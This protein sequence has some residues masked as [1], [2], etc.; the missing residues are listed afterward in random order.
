SGGDE[1][2]GRRDPRTRLLALG[3][4][5][6]AIATRRGRGRPHARLLGVAPLDEARRG[7]SARRPGLPADRR[8]RLAR[9]EMVAA[10]GGGGGCFVRAR[11]PGGAARSRTGLSRAARCR[12]DAGEV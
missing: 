2:R 5:R 3:W 11:N 1:T 12:R 6:K 8:V 10:R 9:G 7:G 4:L